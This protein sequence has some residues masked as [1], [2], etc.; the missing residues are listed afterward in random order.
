M[1]FLALIGLA[2]A[3]P[4]AAEVKASG[5]GGFAVEATRVVPA[6]PA[7]TY[8]ALGRIGSWWNPSHSYSGKAENLS[9]QLRSG[10]CFCEKLADGGSVEHLRVV[11]ARPGTLLR[12][13]GGLGPLQGEG[14]NGSLTYALK[15]VAGGT[16][17]SQTYV[18][19]GFIRS[20]AV[21]LAPMVDAML[22][23]T[24]SRFESSLRD[25]VG[26]ARDQADPACAG[27]SANYVMLPAIAAPGLSRAWG[28]PDTDAGGTS[29]GRSR[30]CRS[31]WFHRGRKAP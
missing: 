21:K 13:T 16:E 27:L 17:V 3:T 7:E 19:G 1:R 31:Q 18:V 22:A 26:K 12:L 6:T 8:A 24:L 9:L 11:S 2:V 25:K 4:A 28:T 23:E 20:G 5:E 14:V 30:A 29:R 15:P 10:G